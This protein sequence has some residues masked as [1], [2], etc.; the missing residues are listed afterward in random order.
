M[1]RAIRTYMRS[2][3]SVAV[4]VLAASAVAASAQAAPPPLVIVQPKIKAFCAHAYATNSESWTLCVSQGT[5]GYVE[6][7]QAYPDTDPQLRAAFDKCQ[8]QFAPQGN[9]ALAGWCARERARYFE[10]LR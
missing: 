10:E 7:A 8:A 3:L 2:C 5:Q 4:V 1:L 9:W 6:F